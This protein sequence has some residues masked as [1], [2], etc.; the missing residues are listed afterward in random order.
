MKE[1][2]SEVSNMLMAEYNV[3]THMEVMEEEHREEIAE[4]DAE[5]ADIRSE[6]TDIRAENAEK[7]AKI[8]ELQAKLNN[9]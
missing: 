5:I 9:K 7:D 3:E 1:Y 2:G 4:K 8:A 6:I